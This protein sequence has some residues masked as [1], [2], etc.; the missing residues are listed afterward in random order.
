L[1]ENQSTYAFKSGIKDR[2]LQ[3]KNCMQVINGFEKPYCIMKP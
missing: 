1:I 3:I 2:D